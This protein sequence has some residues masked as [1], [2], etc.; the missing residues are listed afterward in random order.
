MMTIKS[1]IVHVG[2]APGCNRRLLLATQVADR[3]GA[4]LIGLG[5]EIWDATVGLGEPLLIE[6]VRE[7]RAGDGM[8]AAVGQI[9]DV[10]ALHCPR[11][12]D[13]R[14]ELPDRVIT[15]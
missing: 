1:I 15:L 11:S 13:D 7:G 8:V 5:A 6:A 2:A 10:L 9:G 14:N 12:E 4:A 3:F